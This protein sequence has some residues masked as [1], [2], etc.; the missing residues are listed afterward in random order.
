MTDKPT[1][2]TAK[3][4]ADKA[5]AAADTAATE[6]TQAATTAT[7]TPPAAAAPTA[8]IPQ[9]VTAPLAGHQVP[10]VAGAA[11]PKGNW[12]KEH[13]ASTVIAASLLSLVIGLGGGFA[14]GY[15]G[16]SGSDDGGYRPGHH[17]RWD[18]GDRKWNRDRYGDRYGDRYDRDDQWWGPRRGPGGDDG[19]WGRGYWNDRGP[20]SGGGSGNDGVVPPWLRTPRP[21]T[22]GLQT[23]GVPTP[24]QQAP[25]QQA[26]GQPTGGDLPA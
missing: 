14:L 15:F 4:A 16:T 8:E 12:W 26:P 25:G 13:L 7:T 10:P 18:D 24:G 23:P 17:K 21:T 1:K 2:K 11:E 9:P 20:R 19:D 3:K 5:A 6:A 22:P